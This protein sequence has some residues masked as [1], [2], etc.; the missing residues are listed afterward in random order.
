VILAPGIYTIVVRR[1]VCAGVAFAL[2]DAIL[3]YTQVK[4][5]AVHISKALG[6][7]SRL[8]LVIDTWLSRGTC[9]LV[10]TI[11]ICTAIHTPAVHTSPALPAITVCKTLRIER[12][13]LSIHTSLVTSTIIV[14]LA[15]GPVLTLPINTLKAIVAV[16]IHT[17]FWGDLT[18][19]VHAFVSIRTLAVDA[20]GWDAMFIFADQ[21][22]WTVHVGLALIRDLNARGV[23]A[24]I[25]CRAIRII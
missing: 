9:G 14:C 8:P 17:A 5:W 2:V 13:T 16:C 24:G 23:L 4:I 11:N 3:I 25:S 15:P 7:N 22:S 1:T 10:A 21:F 12:D 20:I 18:S 6:A 19:S